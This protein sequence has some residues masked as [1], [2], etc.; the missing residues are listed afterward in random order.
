MLLEPGV[1]NLEVDSIVLKTHVHITHC[2]ESA[3]SQA[4][5]LA[6]RPVC[7]LHFVQSMSNRHPSILPIA[8][9]LTAL[10]GLA[11]LAC[12]KSNSSAD[13]TAP[14]EQSNTEDRSKEAEVTNLC[15]AYTSCNDCIAGQIDSGKSEGEAQTQCG[16]AV[17][18]CW[19]TWEKPVVCGER[20]YD[21]E[22]S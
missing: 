4:K 11:P 5:T 16:L 3:Q 7:V 19:T 21:D 22:P 20:T 2:A 12:D 9:M 17:T 10:L 6:V 15:S 18:G 14:T 1:L 13:T 8:F